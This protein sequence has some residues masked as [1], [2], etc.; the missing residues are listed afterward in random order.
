[1]LDK[2]GTDLVTSAGQM[3]RTNMLGKILRQNL[4]SSGVGLEE[5]YTNWLHTHPPDSPHLPR[6]TTEIPPLSEKETRVTMTAVRY[7]LHS[8]CWRCTRLNARN[9]HKRRNQSPSTKKLRKPPREEWEE[10]LDL[11]IVRREFG[12]TSY[13]LISKMSRKIL[14]L[15]TDIRNVPMLT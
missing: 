14:G 5:D 11:E 8:A 4:S 9:R 6:L 2:V 1:M 7:T 3:N 13:V 12:L 10:V 15:S